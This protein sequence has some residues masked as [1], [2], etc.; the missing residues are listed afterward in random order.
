MILSG[1]R[2]QKSSA[3]FERC[4]EGIRSF[5]ERLDT[6]IE[7]DE[8]FMSDAV[9]KININ[10]FLSLIK[11][12]LHLFVKKFTYVKLFRKIRHYLLN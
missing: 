3:S 9:L 5:T 2:L 7:A 11:V 12:K 1:K 4:C 6:Y 10:P 8:H